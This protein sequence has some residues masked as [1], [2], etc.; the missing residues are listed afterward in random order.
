MWLLRRG[1]RV[2]KMARQ[3]GRR[4]MHVSSAFSVGNEKSN[5]EKDTMKS[6]AFLAQVG[7]DRKVA[8]YT[9]AHDGKMR[10][11]AYHEELGECREMFSRLLSDVQTGEIRV[12]MTPDASCLWV[13]TSPRWMELLIQAVRR[14][15]V[16]I[17]D[18]GHDLVY[19]LREEDD[20]ERFRG[21]STPGKYESERNAPP[22]PR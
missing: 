4:E 22:L 8:I 17:G 7:H 20:E 21:L 16:L 18:H 6:L 11:F 12:I 14:H 10:N 2:L 1:I 3:W 19:D 9:A 5:R 13:E 15:E